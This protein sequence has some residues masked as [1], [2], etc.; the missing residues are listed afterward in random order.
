MRLGF[1]SWLAWTVVAGFILSAIVFL[2]NPETT[3]LLIDHFNWAGLCILA[4]CF[5]D[6]RKRRKDRIQELRDK[7]NIT[8]N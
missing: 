3:S 1:Y 5:F 4:G 7:F 8:K 6:D 2:I